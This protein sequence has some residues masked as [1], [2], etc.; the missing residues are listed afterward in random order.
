MWGSIILP[1]SSEPSGQESG[2]SHTLPVAPRA[3]T[4]PV[5]P[6]V[7]VLLA[8]SRI[9]AREEKFVW[10]VSGPRVAPDTSL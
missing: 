7:I 3:S 6:K 9:D 1:Q 2:T 10:S 5:P 4:L 8:S